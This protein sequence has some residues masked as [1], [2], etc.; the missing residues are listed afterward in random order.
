MK[1][2]Y[3]NADT[4]LYQ[5]LGL[6]GLSSGSHVTVSTAISK[7]LGREVNTYRLSADQFRALL[8]EV[9]NLKNV[10]A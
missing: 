4:N 1:P 9:R 6:M 2:Q 7:L 3:M 10:R 5:L 8:I